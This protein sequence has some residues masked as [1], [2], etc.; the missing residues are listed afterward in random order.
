MS[1]KISDGRWYGASLPILQN[2]VPSNLQ[3]RPPREARLLETA[4]K[5][6]VES[7]TMAEGFLYVPPDAAMEERDEDE[8]EEEKETMDSEKDTTPDP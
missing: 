1:T 5:D 7:T 2:G 3:G 6:E 4:N 8:G